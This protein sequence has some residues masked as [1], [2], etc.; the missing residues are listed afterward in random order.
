MT[1]AEQ[2]KAERLRE[3]EALILE[4][5]ALRDQKPESLL[6]KRDGGK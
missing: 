2:S 3:L 5:Y 1:G 4:V 6:S